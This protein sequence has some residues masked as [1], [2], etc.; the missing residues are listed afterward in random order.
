MSDNPD[1]SELPYPSTMIEPAEFRVGRGYAQE[2]GTDFVALAALD[3][4]TGQWF[5]TMFGDPQDAINVGQHLIAMG[6]QLQR[7][8]P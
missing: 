4:V 3:R 2:D 8:N 1:H 5:T 7:L 6:A